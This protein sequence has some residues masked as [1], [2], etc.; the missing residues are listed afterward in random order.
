MPRHF[1]SENFATVDAFVEAAAIV[2][3]EELARAGTDLRA[4]MLSGGNTPPRIYRT[5]QGKTFQASARAY[6]MFS[7]ERHVP[8]DDSDSNYGAARS[9]LQGTKLPEERVLRVHTELSLEE[10]AARYDVELQ[11]YLSMGGRI[12]LA[13]IGL[14]PD[15][16]TCSLFEEADLARGVGRMAI[17]VERDPGP[18]RI[19]VTPAL[20]AQVDRII[21]MAVGED[22][23][24]V[25]EQ[26]LAAPEEVVAG[27]ALLACGE[28]EIWRA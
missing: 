18:D 3:R 11:S 2:L 21:V 27:Q 13:F 24:D 22:K 1:Y 26:L 28:V 8:V 14:G 6:V 5:F 16:H 4:V 10:A 15:G 19:S 25:V 23:A 9:F 12:P 17:P 7:D 20:L